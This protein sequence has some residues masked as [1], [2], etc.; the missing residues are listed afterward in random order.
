MDF[1]YLGKWLTVIGL[2]VACLGLLVWLTGR[3]G[4]PF[5]TLPGDIRIERPGFSFRFPLVTC[6]M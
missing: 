3:W 4:I 2:A 5:G 1:S 6:I